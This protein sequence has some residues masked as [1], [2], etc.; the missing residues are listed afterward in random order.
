MASGGSGSAGGQRKRKTN[1]LSVGPKESRVD[2]ARRVQQGGQPSEGLSSQPLADLVD[3]EEAIGGMTTS[4]AEEALIEGINELQG[5]G[6]P[7]TASAAAAVADNRVAPAEQHAGSLSEGQ[8]TPQQ[9]GPVPSGVEISPR[10]RV[11]GTHI[12]LGIS[13]WSSFIDSNATLVDKSAAIAD[14]MD[15]NGNLVIA[16]LYPRRTG[17]STFLNTLASFLGIQDEDL[18]RA[19]RRA[20]FEG[21]TL[22]ETD[23]AFFEAN[24][25]KYPV[26]KFDFK[27]QDPASRGEA[28]HSV[29]EAMLRAVSPYVPLLK[30]IASGCVPTIPGVEVDHIRVDEHKRLASGLVDKIRRVELSEAPPAV[31]GLSEVII[32]LMELFRKLLGVKS[33][34]LVD[35]YDTPFMN[36]LHR[37][38]IDDSTRGAI[39]RVYANFL[40]DILKGNNYLHKGVLVGV[41][42]MRNV[43][44]GSGLNLVETYLAHSGIERSGEANPFQRA[45]GFTASDVWGLVCTFVESLWDHR[46][47]CTNPEQF[48][49]DLLVKCIRRFDGYRIGQVRCVFNTYVVVRFFEA[50]RQAQQNDITASGRSFW[51]QTGSMRTIESIQVESLE[52]FQRLLRCLMTVY[53]YRRAGQSDTGAIADLDNVDRVRDDMVERM[54]SQD[55]PVYPIDYDEGAHRMLASIC[56]G[57]GLDST[58][59]LVGLGTRPLSAAAAIRLLYQAGYLTP[60]SADRVGIPNE[61]VRDA[62]ED[63]C[64]KV[65]AKHKRNPADVDAVNESIGIYNGKLVQLAGSLNTCMMTTVTGLSTKTLEKEYHTMFSAF[66][67]P[68][69]MIGYEVSSQAPMENGASD[70]IVCPGVRIT[71]HPSSKPY[72]YVFELK[73]VADDPD[74]TYELQMRP[75]HRQRVERGIRRWAFSAL[76]QIKERYQ[77]AAA[78]RA[79]HCTVLYTV[80]IAFWLHRFFLVAKKYRRRERSDGLVD[81]VDV[82]YEDADVAGASTSDKSASVENGILV[83]STVCSN[84]TLN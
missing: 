28:L 11:H 30:Q 19:D 79:R 65:V 64:A 25:G 82:P 74:M 13:S 70:V 46:H 72:Y 77:Q 55:Q 34:V 83:V 41:F 22:F 81:W 71:E 66:V 60:I 24:F 84:G 6:Q 80:G 26:I 36:A 49:R 53:H 51:V 56:M 7:S 48:K 69:R 35:E 31:N 67:H 12:Q 9:N 40:C 44:L 18:S 15:R 54:G 14:V 2:K 29:G 76:T 78:V 38:D 58:T 27:T 62:L 23:R 68:A 43:G 39:H 75:A 21:S 33:V 37:P 63:Y 50:S 42:D 59:D 8:R 61:E 3:W 32:S 17:K 16:G 1:R 45:F 10:S 20:A 4:Q 5:G 73:R 47:N 52:L 57:Q